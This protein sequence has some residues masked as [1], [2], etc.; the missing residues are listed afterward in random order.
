MKAWSDIQNQWAQN[1]G[2]K[3]LTGVLLWDLSAAFDCLD[4]GILCK[5]LKYYSLTEKTI[6]WLYWSNIKPSGKSGVT[7]CLK[8]QDYCYVAS[9]YVVDSG[10]N[11]VLGNLI[12]VVSIDLFSLSFR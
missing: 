6:Q 1:S 3:K 9:S 5:K 11:L 10:S 8:L 2:G 7:I 12:K 4:P